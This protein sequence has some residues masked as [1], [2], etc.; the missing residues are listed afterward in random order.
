MA[1]PSTEPSPQKL[2]GETEEQPKIGIALAAGGAKGIAH[3]PMLE[4]LDELGITPHRIAGS[5]IGAVIG[6]LYASGLK[7][8]EIKDKVAHLAITKKD[9]FRSVLSDHK[10]GKWMEMIDADFRHS[11]LLKTE[12]IMTGLYE[13]GLS[14]TFEELAIPLSVVATD[15]WKRRA[16]VLES[17]PVQPAVQASMA[18]PGVF[19]P[20]ELDG[21][22]LIDGGTVNPVPLVIKCDNG[23]AFASH[24]VKQWAEAN[25]VR[26][27]FS[28]SET[29]AYNGA[30]E[31]GIGS[32]KTRATWAAARHNRPADW[33]CDDIEA[34][35]CEANAMARPRGRF[36]GS[37]N[38]AWHGRLPLEK[39]DR[40]RFLGVYRSCYARERQR[41]GWPD[42]IEL[43][44]RQ[45]AALDRV[46]I[47][48]ALVE[49]GLLQFR[50]RRITLPVSAS[51][52]RKIS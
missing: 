40:E 33:T 19:T 13:D 41:H 45:Q 37:P 7:A 11:G 49:K 8:Q 28:P 14:S 51:K 46:A 48:R 2:E 36:G 5:S 26:L 43:Q 47:T 3:I 18:L 1:E 12:S 23:S 39:V 27:L 35:H 38:D 17:G 29:P 15:F 44:H 42:G 30:I 31:A 32:I 24:E 4:A 25:N 52:S 16:V 21:R 9:T 50:R 34:A 6:A 20:V 10:I 22:V